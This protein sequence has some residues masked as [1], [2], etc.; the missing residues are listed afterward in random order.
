MT[1]LRK[2]Y[3]G[4][5]QPHIM[6][7]TR[8]RFNARL[9]LAM[10]LP[11]SIDLSLEF[12]PVR[13]QGQEGA[14]TAFAW[15]G[16]LQHMAMRQKLQ[17]A[18]LEPSEQAFYYQERVHG[19]YDINQDTGAS[20]SDG[21]WVA[22]NIGCVKNTDFPYSRPLNTPPPGGPVIDL[23]TVCLS[24]NQNAIDIKTAL[25]EG[26]GVP[27]GVVVYESFEDA[28]L[29]EIPMPNVQ[30]E[31]VL[32][33]HAIVLVGYNDGFQQFKFR[34]SWSSSWGDEG[35]GYLPYA[36]VLNSD[37]ASDFWTPRAVQ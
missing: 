3:G 10:V 24:V 21:A 14:C 15:T 12:P 30:A 1:R 27:F 32:G 20:L 22:M 37:L 9:S 2:Y 36:Y 26:Y 28:K 8:P 5:R 11:A 18:T 35:Y 29:G 6:W 25:V 4:W 33:G 17:W 19:K 13:D 34:N 23:A 16:A 7:A 31:Q